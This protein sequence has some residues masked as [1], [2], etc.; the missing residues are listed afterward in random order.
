MLGGLQAICGLKAD[1]SATYTMCLSRVDE[2][3]FDQSSSDR[4]QALAEIREAL[5]Q[6]Q[7]TFWQPQSHRR[8]RWGM[9]CASYFTNA[10]SEVKVWPVGMR[11]PRTPI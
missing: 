3:A 6:G 7:S 2:L 8:A 9:S 10:G 11:I 4:E 5:S 1:A